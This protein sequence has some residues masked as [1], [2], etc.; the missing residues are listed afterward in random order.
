MSAIP[1]SLSNANSSSSSRE[2]HTRDLSFGEAG[3]TLIEILV[4]LAIVLMIY[5]AFTPSFAGLS[6]GASFKASVQLLHN[7]LKAVRAQAILNGESVHLLITEQ[8]RS[9]IAGDKIRNLSN[10]S[11]I[12]HTGKSS[13]PITYYP[14]GKSDGYAITLSNSDRTASLNSNWL[15]GDI[16]R[17]NVEAKKP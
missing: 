5:G 1:N 4:V 2:L 9:Y 11:R 10:E 15:T 13:N 6:S 8:G 14:N 3:F 16:E 12:N 7:D 17:T